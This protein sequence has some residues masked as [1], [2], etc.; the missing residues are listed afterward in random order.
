MQVALHLIMR[1]KALAVPQTISLC[2][3]Q[4]RIIRGAGGASSCNMNS[5]RID[6]EQMW[7]ANRLVGS[8]WYEGLHRKFVMPMD[9]FEQNIQP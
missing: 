1:P 9:A 7:A 3:T 8:V 2:L 6:V 4:L 5:G